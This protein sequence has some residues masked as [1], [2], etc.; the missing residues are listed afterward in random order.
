[1]FHE[2]GV[3]VIISR[4]IARAMPPGRPVYGLQSPGLNDAGAPLSS[5]AAMA[6]R[7]VH[8]IRRVHP[9]GP[10]VLAGGS[11][12]GVVA[13]EVAR[14]LLDAGERIAVLGLFDTAVPGVGPGGGE[15]PWRPHRWPALYRRLDASQRAWLWRRIAFRL[16][17]LPLM[18]LR[19]WLGSGASLPRELRIHLVERSNQLAL[20]AYRPQP[21]RGRVV[22]FKA[23]RT[24]PADDPTLGWGRLAGDVDVIDVEARHDSVVEQPELVE[25]FRECVAG[26]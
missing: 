14:R 10:Y 21:Y 26:S 15:S 3:K 18:R 25:R 17:R 7:Y 11:M 19:Q 22:L 23:T 9:A 1:M 24:G 8:E 20:A 12:G 6:D 13:L 4:Q 2:V 5:I 16:W